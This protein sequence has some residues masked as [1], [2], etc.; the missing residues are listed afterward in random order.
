MTEAG[1]RAEP[2]LGRRALPRLGGDLV[3][4]SSR[5]GPLVT[6]S[7]WLDVLGLWRLPGALPHTCIPPATTWMDPWLLPDAGCQLKLLNKA[8]AKSVPCSN[9]FNGSLLPTE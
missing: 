2:L 1:R 9:P 6:Q 5:D 8:F 7:P 3:P 4:V